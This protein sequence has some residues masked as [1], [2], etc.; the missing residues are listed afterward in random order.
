MKIAE[1][2]SGKYILKKALDSTKDQ[3][4]VLYN[5]TQEQLAENSA[6]PIRRSPNGKTASVCPIAASF[7]SSATRSM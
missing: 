6:C 7:K 4:Y 2:P 1:N 3:S 5:L